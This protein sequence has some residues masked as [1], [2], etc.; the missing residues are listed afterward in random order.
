[1]NLHYY[2]RADLTLQDWTP[3]ATPSYKVTGT[4]LDD[5]TVTV[6]LD[7]S[8]YTVTTPPVYRVELLGDW[9]EKSD[10]GSI[11]HKDTVLAKTDVLTVSRGKATATF[12]N[13]PEYIGDANNL[14]L[15]IWYASSGLGPV[16]T[17]WNVNSETDANVKELS[18][19]EN[20]E[21]V[22]TYLHSTTLQSSVSNYYKQYQYNSTG[23]LFTW[24]PKPDFKDADS[25]TAMTPQYNGDKLLYTFQWD[26]GKTGSDYTNATYQVSLTGIDANGNEVIIS[27]EDAYKDATAK[28]LTIDGSDWNYTS[29][30][31]KVTRI[32]YTAQ[33][34]STY[35]GLS[36]TGTYT[37]KPRLEA[38]A[39]PSVTIV[40]QN[41]LDYTL[42]WA[43]NAAEEGMKGYQ[44]YVQ[45]YDEQGNL[46]EAAELG[47]LVTTNKNQKGIYTETVSM[48]DY[49]GQKVVIYLK[50][51][52]DPNGAYLDSLPGI[53]TE[54]TIP[55]RLKQPNVT[56]KPSWTYNKDVPTG[57]DV[58]LNHL[59][60]DLTADKGSI[61]PGGSGYLL[62]AYVFDTEAEAKKAT[63]DTAMP[64]GASFVYPVSYGESK[65]PVQ[66]DVT[67][68]TD[69]YHVL[70]NLS[71][72]Y[73]GKWIV[74]YAR[75]SSGSG[76][77]S[78][79]WT[80][81]SNPIRL[82]KVQLDSP[83]VASN[84][85]EGELT[86]TVT[87]TPNVPG[88]ARTWSADYTTLTWDSV[89]CADLYTFTLEGSRTNDGTIETLSATYRIKETEDGLTLEYKDEGGTC[90]TIDP[91]E[92]DSTAYSLEGYRVEVGGNYTPTGST[93][94]YSYETTL[95][96]KLTVT[97][98][99]DGTRSYQLTLPDVSGV[100]ATD[101]LA[102]GTEATT[103][104]TNDAFRLTTCVSIT[105]DVQENLDG[106]TS[107]AYAASEPNKTTFQ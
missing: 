97:S 65:I 49:A 53:T 44:A 95:T 24:L 46:Q 4:T 104:I 20:G 8:S 87:T 102:N 57:A 18:Q 9:I 94:N 47:E 66:M 56:W 93:G 61:P 1:M 73:A 28:I 17:Y 23:T 19:D 64:T 15:R 75:I 77:V 29:V 82:P 83:S 39:Q 14:S 5:L 74:F 89:D 96:A 37:I 26:Q 21:Y 80:Q 103:V 92:D 32:G 72:K 13:L 78:S 52:A 34:G 60:I 55:S 50:A 76:T 99:E 85:E 22:W 6:T 90:K 40:D 101:R 41:E 68:T 106:Q 7:A 31:L 88:T 58:F 35:I 43:A 105:A 100:T 11:T 2:Y 30:K 10:T 16:Y 33:N 71:I 81:A 67:S 62:R 79:A 84:S 45:T 70:Q 107:E 69:Y 86:A 98:H 42:T 48:E 59:Q 51:I 63:K 36:S 38:P 12:Q 3:Q 25:D 54:V 27:T 91:T